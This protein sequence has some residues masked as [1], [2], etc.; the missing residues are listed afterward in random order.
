MACPML[1]FLWLGN[2]YFSG[3][4]P[5][6]IGYLKDLQSLHLQNNT[7]SGPLRQS[8][9]NCSLLRTLDLSK[10]SFTRNL[11]TWIG[12]FHVPMRFLNLRSNRLQGEIPIELCYLTHL[13]ILDIAQNN[14][15]G[16]IPMCFKNLTAMTSGQSYSNTT[17]LKDMLWTIVDK[18]NDVRTIPLFEETLQVLLGNKC[19]LRNISKTKVTLKGQSIVLNCITAKYSFLCVAPK[20]MMRIVKYIY[21]A[22]SGNRTRIFSLTK[23]NFTIRPIGPDT[24]GTRSKSCTP[25]NATVSS[26]L[27]QKRYQ[28]SQQNDKMDRIKSIFISKTTRNSNFVQVAIPRFDGHHD[29][30]NVL[31]EYI[32]RLWSIGRNFKGYMEFIEEKVSN[33]FEL[34]VTCDDGHDVG[35]MFIYDFDR[36]GIANK[37]LVCPICQINNKQYDNSNVT[38]N[39]EYAKF[40]APKHQPLKWFTTSSVQDFA[41]SFWP[42]T[43]VMLKQL[44]LMSKVHY[45]K[46]SVGYGKYVGRLA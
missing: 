45:K 12:K 44:V 46:K 28:T 22:D 18:R 32:L 39:L 4:I 15:Y 17:W 13:Q 16:R 35:G 19:L 40:N 6:S 8:L 11:P 10:N 26:K 36:R 33:G 3:Q 27:S 1:I 5:S 20:T 24:L 21:N 25:V 42:S 14:F 41:H 43:Y 29:H 7:L 31:M 38:S 30:W 9:Q 37:G 34:F 2:N 23:R